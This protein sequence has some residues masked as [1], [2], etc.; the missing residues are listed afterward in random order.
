M[1]LVLILTVS[2]ISCGTQP[3]APPTTPSESPSATPNISEPPAEIKG[4]GETLTIMISSGDNDKTGLKT[5]LEMTAELL[6]VKIKYN[7]FPSDQM[8]NVVNT[9][10]ATGNADDIIIH[11]FG[12]TDVSAKDLA[13]L[14]GSWVDKIRSN[15]KPICVD[16]V[17]GEVLKAPFGSA[18]NMGLLYNKKVL[19]KA[20]VTLPLNNYAE[21]IEACDKIKASGVTPVYISNKEV[22]TAQIPLLCS[23]TSTIAETPYLLQNLATNKVK[24]ADVPELKKLWENL[25]SLKTGG[26]INTDY[27]SATNGMGFEALV[28]GQCAFYAHLDG[29]YGEINDAYPDKINDIGMTFCPL[30]DDA[31]KGY[32]LFG[33][34]SNYISVVNNSKH[35]ELA[36]E[37]VNVM[38]S[39][40]VLTAYYDLMPGASPFNDLGFELAMSPFN[41]EMNDYAADMKVYGDFNNNVY[42]EGAIFEAFYGRFNEN[43]QNLIA[44]KTVE[45]AMDDWY[46]AYAEDAAARRVEGFTK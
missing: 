44:G 9:K 33:S 2:L 1:L 45:E 12:L 16:P 43:I 46:Q 32:V 40:E 37:F 23:M 42:K 19:E 4:N 18:S 25:L 3:I 29:A 17:S 41:K 38:L 31:D 6:N 36:K 28:N 15:V 27:M 26:Y 34:S 22:W 7:V 30:W 13:P 20:N 14:S 5:A 24:P 35:L 8:L 11:V 39:K 21:L 10:L